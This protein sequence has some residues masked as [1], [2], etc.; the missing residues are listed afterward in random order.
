[1]RPY[2]PSPSQEDIDVTQRIVECGKLLGIELLDHI[3]I[4]DDQYYS[5]KEKG[6]I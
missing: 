2:D 3:I 5:L 4:G 1:M 6:Y